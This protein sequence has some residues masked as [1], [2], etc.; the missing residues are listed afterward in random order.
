MF[1]MPKFSRSVCSS[2][3]QDSSGLAWGSDDISTGR[4]PGCVSPLWSTLWS[5]SPLKSCPSPRLPTHTNNPPRTRAAPPASHAH[6]QPPKTRAAP[7]PAP[8][9]P[10]IA[11]PPPG[12]KL[13]PPATGSQR[14]EPVRSSGPDPGGAGGLGGDGG[15]FPVY[16]R[17]SSAGPDPGYC[18][19]PRGLPKE[20]DLP[21]L[22][23]HPVPPPLTTAAVR[24]FPPPPVQPLQP[25]RGCHG[26]HR[27]P[28]I[29]SQQQRL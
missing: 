13:Y 1:L 24:D 15:G 9:Y 6:Q 17:A 18:A 21:Q 25:H 28:K 20:P 14:P 29:H 10:R 8:D 2:C 7:P 11:A 4:S 23:T 3:F 12:Q 5:S 26:P 27:G 19:G 16:L 22:L